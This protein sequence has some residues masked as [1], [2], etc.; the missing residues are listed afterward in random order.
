MTATAV[1]LPAKAQGF[2][3]SDLKRSIFLQAQGCR[4]AVDPD[5]AVR[6]LESLK[7]KRALFGREQVWFYKV[8]AGIVVHA[9]RPDWGVRVSPRHVGFAGRVFD[10]EVSQSV[11]FYAGR[12]VG[13][14]RKIKARNVGQVPI[15]LR[16]IELLDPTAAHFA[17]S[18]TGWGSLGVNAFNRESHVA[19]DEVSDPPSARV[20][21]AVP[22]PSKFYMTTSRTRASEILSTG[23]LPEATA[24]MSGQVLVL[25]MHELELAVGE[26]REFS[27]ASLYNPE[28]LEDVLSD[29]RRLQAGERRVTAP[30]PTIACSEAT[31]SEA[32]AWALAAIPGGAYADDSLDSY[33]ALRALA[34]VDPQLAWQTISRTRDLIRKDGSLPH[35]LDPSK[36]GVLETAVF[37]QAACAYLASSQDKKLARATYPSIKKL[38]GSLMA[39]SKD[40]GVQTDPSLPQGWRRNLGRG[41]PT[42]EIPEVSLAA[43]EALDGASGVA[44]MMSK[45]EDS[46]KF[47]ERS[48]MISEHVRKKLLDERG[49]ISLCRDSSGRLRNDETVDMAVAAYRHQFMASAEQACAHRLLEKDFDTRYGPRC[50]PTTNQVYFNGS[51]GEGQ[52]GGLWTR[53]ALAHAILCYRGGLGGIGSLALAR[54]SRL[55]VDD[56]L[57]LGG[58]PGEFPMWVDVDG[59]IDHGDG[60]DPVAAARF[61]EAMLVG[62]L[63]LSGGTDKPTFSPAASSGLG[64]LL[65]SDLWAGEPLS[66]FLGR[67]SGK[68]QVFYVGG[69]IDKSGSKFAKAM[70]LDVPLKGVYGLSFH[71]PG[72]VICLGTSLASQIR[73]T[74]S[75][76]P[77]AAELSKRLSTPLE[78]YDPAKGTW[79]KTGSL[80]VFPTMSF[81]ASLEANGW[82]AYRVSSA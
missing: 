82:K 50:V 22:S 32:A 45:T 71:G 56:A 75:F 63:G 1:S 3:S 39:V 27:F 20:A 76:Q 12:S 41:Y 61:V 18:S 66:V 42:G 60:S 49:F 30:G 34:Y 55:V 58:S 5:G 11:E 59:S 16:I 44:R 73:F 43:A 53:A 62:E 74:V 78:E 17:G 64:W 35:S 14:I 8:Q 68:A 81:E 51:Y 77:R 70:R 2:R 25:A 40:F 21:G 72:Q 65:V 57:K 48:A 4:L 79:S 13:L 28:K 9:Q 29:F 15:R 7:E 23:E 19:M 80:R 33:E 52:L 6:A 47:R 54:V 38:A 24:G 26:S 10:V 46:G 31:V 67:G 69:R 36:P 37:L